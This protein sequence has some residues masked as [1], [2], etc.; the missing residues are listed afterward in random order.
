[1]EGLRFDL[2]DGECFN[3][4]CNNMSCIGTVGDQKMPVRTKNVQNQ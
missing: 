1:M 4:S 2:D 3:M